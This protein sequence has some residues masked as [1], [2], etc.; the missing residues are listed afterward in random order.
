MEGPEK[1]FAFYNMK[2]LF[3]P[4]TKAFSFLLELQTFKTF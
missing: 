1:E 4:E 2:Y 3:C